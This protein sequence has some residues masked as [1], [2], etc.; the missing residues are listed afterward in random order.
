M[1]W[2][3][4]ISESEHAPGLGANC[5]NVVGPGQ[6]IRYPES[7]VLKVFDMFQLLA[8]QKFNRCE[9]PLELSIHLD[10]SDS[11]ILKMSFMKTKRVRVCST[12]KLP[13]FVRCDIQISWED[14]GNTD[15]I[16]GWTGISRAK[17]GCKEAIQQGSLIHS[18]CCSDGASG[19]G[20]W[21]GGFMGFEWLQCRPKFLRGVFLLEQRVWKKAC[22]AKRILE[23]TRLR[24]LC[25]LQTNLEAWIP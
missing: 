18:G 9:Q 17:T 20:C 16:V 22:L 19:Q 14:L 12:Q 7:K 6:I 4:P 1:G 25:T 11:W 13:H 15:W 23:T 10:P 21:Q 5:F 8:I 3:K 2:E 24:R